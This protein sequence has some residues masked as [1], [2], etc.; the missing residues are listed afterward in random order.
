VIGAAVALL[1]LSAVLHAVSQALI[2]AARD[3]RAFAWLSIGLSSLVGAPILIISGAGRAEPIG[4]CIAAASGA[5]EAL[6]FSTLTKAY[7]V[8]DFSTVYPVARGS[9]PLF[10]LAW[11]VAFLGER[12]SPLGMAGILVVCVGIYLVGL[13]SIAEWKRPFA[14]AGGGAA[15]WALATGLA[16]SCYTAVDKVGLR[17]FDPAAY[18]VVVMASAWLFQAPTFMG[19]AGREALMAELRGAVRDGRRFPAFHSFARVALCSALGFTAYALVLAALKIA[20][21]SYVAPTREIGVVLGA[22]IGV[23]RFGER[24]GPSRVLA[25]AVVAAGIAAISLSR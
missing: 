25:S 13:P 21:A 16:I 12:P 5:I 8:G 20:P 14:G 3:N 7:S 9:A 2:K 4:W 24:G 10:T 18:L 15:P 19:K 17:Y 1:V 11:A 23:R 6:Y 22:W